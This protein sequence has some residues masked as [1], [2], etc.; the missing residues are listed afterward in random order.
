MIKLAIFDLD[1][2][3]LNT[4]PDLTSAMNHAME[5]MGRPR[6]TCRHT[7]RYIG[8][9]IQKF[10]QRALGEDATPEEAAEAVVY[11]KE[12]YAGHLADRTVPYDG[13]SEAI[14]EIKSR[15][16]YC[17]VLSN[18]YDEATQYII[19]R[20][21]PDT[22]DAVRGEGENCKR[23]PDPGCFLSLCEK[24]GCKPSEAVMI[25]DS[26]TDLS[27]AN[28]AKSNHIIVTWGYRSKKKM[29]ELGAKVFAKTPAEIVT[30]IDTL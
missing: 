22:F 21:F 2:T 18:K 17:A 1:G 4:I 10:A 26:G 9:G 14:A 11:F 27:A 24:F 23:K 29:K 13:I 12:Y 25:G 15:G 3:I 8:N 20:Y 19:N 5:E 7:R 30:L 6:I 16:I 28:N